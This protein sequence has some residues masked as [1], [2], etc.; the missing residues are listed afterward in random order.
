MDNA[1]FRNY[2]YLGDAVWELFVREH[3]VSVTN[4]PKKL[5]SVT[6]Q[7]VKASFQADMLGLLSSGFTDEECE[8]VRRA[9]NLPVPTARRH[10]QAEYRHATAFEAIIGF[11]YLFDKEKL[12]RKF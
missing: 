10:N 9:G 7:N 2:A 8:L 12:L 3:T 1:D 6:V 5:H 4:N 11:W